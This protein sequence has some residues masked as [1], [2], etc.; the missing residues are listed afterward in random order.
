MSIQTNF[1]NIKPY[2]NLLL[3]E[4]FS[5]WDDR[6]AM[7]FARDAKN[8][9]LQHYTDKAWAIL[10]DSTEWNL[11]T[12]E[13]EQILTGLA[14]GKFTNTITHHALVTGRSEI[15]NWQV[16]KIFKDITAYEAQ[17]F[18]DIHEAEIWLASFGYHKTEL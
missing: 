2:I 1:Y 15:K 11:G 17:V 6:V 14:N 18:E 8:I 16:A 3:I 9:I 7:N 10:H 13:T 12:P 5:S 4:S